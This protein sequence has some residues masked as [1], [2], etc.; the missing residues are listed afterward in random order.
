MPPDQVAAGIQH[1]LF[2]QQPQQQQQVQQQWYRSV[3]CAGYSIPDHGCSRLP[4]NALVDHPG[5]WE[6]ARL[7]YL[8]E[9]LVRRRGSPAVMAVLASEVHRQMLLLG[10]IDFAVTFDY[11]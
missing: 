11:G 4:P 2:K 1:A 9:A 5:V 10:A 7:A 3:A 8:S 6:D